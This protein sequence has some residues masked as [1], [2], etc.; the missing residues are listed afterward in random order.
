MA[1]YDKE[2][3]AKLQ[4][5][6]KVKSASRSK[7]LAEKLQANLDSQIKVQWERPDPRAQ[8]CRPDQGLAG[9][10]G[11]RGARSRA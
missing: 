4:A 8:A 9:G 2:I 1:R 11:S 5:E 6:A 7:A 3:A 10:G